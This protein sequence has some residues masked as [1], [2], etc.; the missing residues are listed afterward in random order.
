[1]GPHP[2]SNRFETK[3]N[4]GLFQCERVSKLHLYVKARFT[5]I[6]KNFLKS[7]CNTYFK[8]PSILT[9]SVIESLS[10]EEKCELLLTDPPYSTRLKKNAL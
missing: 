1:M 4:L 5:K 7:Y 10:L 3:Q 2:G 8:L 6:L 9:T